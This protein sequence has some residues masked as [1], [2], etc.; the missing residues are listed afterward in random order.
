MGH[1]ASATFRQLEISLEAVRSASLG[2]AQ[3][4]ARRS[5]GQPAVREAVRRGE[6]ASM[7]TT[8]A[9]GLRVG[10]SRLRKRDG[11]PLGT[12]G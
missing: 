7:A 2:G 1:V 4:V 8:M 9:A 11:A 5:P 6:W 3:D 12:R 10:V